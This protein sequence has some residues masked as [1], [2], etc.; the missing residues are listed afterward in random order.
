MT[1]WES[2]HLCLA[3]YGKSR[4]IS[5][6]CTV[7]QS[8]IIVQ[9]RCLCLNDL[10]AMVPH[11]RDE[12][13]LSATVFIERWRGCISST[14]PNLI[15]PTTRPEIDKWVPFGHRCVDWNTLDL[16]TKISGRLSASVDKIVRKSFLMAVWSKLILPHSC[17]PFLASQRWV[18]GLMVPFLL[19]SAASTI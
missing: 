17:R 4:H 16:I 2:V 1:K 13:R 11:R 14:V 12:L 3:R 9:V 10:D 18:I 5:C 19:T 8:S 6:D 15:S 7:R